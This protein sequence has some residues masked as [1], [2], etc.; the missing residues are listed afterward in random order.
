MND[1]LNDDGRPS[2]RHQLN[3]GHLVMG[4]ALLGILGIWAL[5]QSDTVGGDDVRWLM[6]IPWVLAGAAG[7]TATAITGSRRYAV[8]QTGWAGGPE[9][10]PTVQIPTDPTDP[11]EERP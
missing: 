8:R 2:G 1:T 3:I 10:T 11:T 6:P 9:P 4:I 7:L 5:V